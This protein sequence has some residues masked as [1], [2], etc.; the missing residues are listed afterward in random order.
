MYDGFLSRIYDVC[1]YFGR[2]RSQTAEYYLSKLNDYYNGVVLELGTATGSI[3][4]PLLKAGYY[5]DTV[6][7]SYD[8]HKIA[9]HKLERCSEECQKRVEF[10]LADITQLIPTKKY[11]AIIIPDSLLAIIE[12]SEQ[13]KQVL[14][15]CYNALKEKGTLLFDIYK[16]IDTLSTDNE[17]IDAVR[18]RDEK[19]NTYVVEVKHKIDIQEQRQTSYYHYKIRVGSNKYEDI[20]SFKIVY[21]YKYLMQIVELLKEVGFIDIESKEIFDNA[22]YFIA[23]QK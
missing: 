19:K 17:Y 23:A 11:D 13:L 7:Y 22:I 1:P 20:A 9:K 10:I 16:P 6:D 12:T 5:I 8:M 3:T 2:D 21:Y 15:M 14:E 4:I 18:F